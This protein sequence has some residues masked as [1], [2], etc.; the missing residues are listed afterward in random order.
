MTEQHAT[1]SGAGL[2]VTKEAFRNRNFSLPFSNPDYSPPEPEEIKA[3][4]SFAGWSQSEV[5]RIVGVHYV[6]GKGSS[7][8]RKWYAPKESNDY[9]PINYA[10]WRLL[11][12]HAGI[13]KIEED[14]MQA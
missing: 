1:Y 13:V 10:A 5:A 6:K 3:L 11:L 14:T 2:P 8:V 9:R 7:A 4:I 12:L